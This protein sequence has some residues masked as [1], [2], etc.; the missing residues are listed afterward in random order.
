MLYVLGKSPQP[1]TLVG[2]AGRGRRRGSTPKSRPVTNKEEEESFPL[3]DAKHGNGQGCQIGRNKC[4]E[5]IFG[6]RSTE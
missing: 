5:K 6:L 2:R 1:K 4:Q 3:L